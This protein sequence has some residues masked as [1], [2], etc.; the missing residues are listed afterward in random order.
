[1]LQ[2]IMSLSAFQTILWLSKIGLDVFMPILT[3]LVINLKEFSD[4]CGHL[5][6]SEKKN[7][8]VTM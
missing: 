4:F 2:F 3:E 7:T 8:K 6:N 1:M 5:A